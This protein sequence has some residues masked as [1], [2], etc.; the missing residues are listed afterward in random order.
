MTGPPSRLSLDMPPASI[1]GV[2]THPPGARITFDTFPVIAR[3]STAVDRMRRIEQ[4]TDP[5]LKGMRWA[6]LKDRDRLSAARCIGRDAL[7]AKAASRRTARARLY[8]KHRR[9]IRDRRQIN[10]VSRLLTQWCSTVPHSKVL[11]MT[12]V[13]RMVRSC[14]DGIV[15]RTRR[16][17]GV[18]KALNG[19]FRAAK[20]KARGYTRFPTMRTVLFLIA[21]K[22]DFTRINPHAA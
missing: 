3:A 16:T 18:I 17:N 11:P 14:L 2:G 4:K 6:L 15:A 7:I 12:G 5:T 9:E 8:R 21:G 10:A 19:L 22:P 1:K 20:R 13:A